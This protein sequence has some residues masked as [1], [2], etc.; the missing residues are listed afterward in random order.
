MPIRLRDE[1]LESGE[2]NRTRPYTVGIARHKETLSSILVYTEEQNTEKE[3]SFDNYFDNN[4]VKPVKSLI[5]DSSIRGIDDVGTGDP[6]NNDSG[7]IALLSL[8]TKNDYYGV[9]N[10]FS[11]LNVTE[12]SEQIIK[13][14]VN[15][16]ASWNAF[17]FGEKPQIFR[18]EGFFLDSSDYPY[19]QEFMVAY[20]KYLSGR[21]SIENKMQTKFVY[22]GKIVNGYLLN[23]STSSTAADQLTKRFQFTVLVTGT[24]WLRTN[25]IPV[26]RNV[27][28]KEVIEIDPQLNGMSNAQ[29]LKQQVIS[30]ILKPSGFQ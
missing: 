4:L 1:Y 12:S 22:D 25:D 2:D 16:G 20:H 11:L 17:F 14:H 5:S 27:G 23:I 10:N 30:G 9:F 28:G 3:N 8:D 13:L 19:Y 21:K 15:F 29:R 26:S 7:E 6:T 18:Y 24:T